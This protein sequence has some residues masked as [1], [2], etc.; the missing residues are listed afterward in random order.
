MFHQDLKGK[1]KKERNL[2]KEKKRK[3]EKERK[4]EKQIIKI[5]GT[6]INDAQLT[7]VWLNFLHHRS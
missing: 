4:N 5:C 3:K 2:K 7:L 1:R 6:M